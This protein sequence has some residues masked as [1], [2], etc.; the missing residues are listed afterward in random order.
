MAA[1]RPKIYCGPRQRAPPGY[2]RVGNNVE[3]M[4]RGFGICLYSGKCGSL[5]NP[6]RAPFVQQAGE[7]RTYCGLQE[8]IPE[9]YTR[10]GTKQ[11]CLRK[12][13]GICL[14]GPPQAIPINANAN[15]A[16]P[17]QLVV[18][19]DPWW[20]IKRWWFWVIVVL[21]ILVII[22]LTLYLVQK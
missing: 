11:E 13:Y 18:P 16:A 21:V 20:I 14:Y 6:E 22:F 12:G 9:G 2:D 19:Y 8:N 15:R 4:K 7:P 17:A 3:C 1:R 5:H 10:Q